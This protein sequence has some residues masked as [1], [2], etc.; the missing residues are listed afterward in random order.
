MSGREEFEKWADENL[1][2]GGDKW[3]AG[4]GW[5]ARQPEIDALKVRASHHRDSHL[6]ALEENAAL[7]AQINLLTESLVSANKAVD[8]EEAKNAALHAEVE[9]LKTGLAELI[10]DAEAYQKA[11]ERLIRGVK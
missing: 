7:K 10:I 4:Q 1:M 9:Q 3:A 2:Y 6:A 8:N 11:T 5:N